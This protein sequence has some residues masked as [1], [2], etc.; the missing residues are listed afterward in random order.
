MTTEI[1]VI[2]QNRAAIQELLTKAQDRIAAVLPG[3]IKVDRMISVAME[4]IQGD[5]KLSLCEPL[6]IVKAVLE[7]SQLGL[8]LNKHLGH[9]Y[10]VPFQNGILTEKYNRPVYDAQFLIGYRG[11]V[12][13]VMSDSPATSVYGR[14]VYAGE[15]FRISEGTQHQLIHVPSL[16][17][18]NLK[19]YIG[20]YAVV[21]Y[22]DGTAPDFE[23]MP[24]A[25]IEKV[26]AFSK[27]TGPAS[28][29]QTWTEEMIKKT[30][31]RRLCKRLKLS[32]EVVAATVR[33]EYREL[34]YEH[35][36]PEARQVM[37]PRRA[38][39]LPPAPEDQEKA[40]TKPA[41]LQAP[42]VKDDQAPAKAEPP[43]LEPPHTDGASIVGVIKSVEVIDR[44]DKKFA[45]VLFE[46]GFCLW[47][48]KSEDFD[49]LK[50]KIGKRIAFDY[51][52]SQKGNNVYHNIVDYWI[53][54]DEQT[55]NE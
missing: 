40:E 41:A 10:L 33:D 19:D 34:G 35:G 45:K 30:P 44:G 3:Q 51:K 18:R 8:L 25:E 7:A 9:G 21:I 4:L 31:L 1:E 27:A 48:F 54:P 50:S 36:K 26:R 37:M 17:G 55:S 6:S 23:W 42:A 32:P 14:I 47:T 24:K 20:A 49:D 29:W 43:R 39:E 12:H 2:S 38:S 28:P 5:S 15:E 16:E 22:K 13:L 11:F 53:A 52:D 46:G